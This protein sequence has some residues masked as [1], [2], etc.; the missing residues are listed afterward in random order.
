M[1]ATLPVGYSPSAIAYDSGKGEIFVAI[2]GSN[3]VSVIS[4]SSNT[5]VANV[6]VGSL[7]HGVAYDSSKGE[8]F[9]ANTNDG[10]VSV[11]SDVSGTSVSSSPTVPE[12]SNQAL[13]LVVLAMVAVTF[14]KVALALEKST[15][16]T[17]DSKKT[18]E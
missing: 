14:C 18:T 15:R 4:D 17:S 3:S 12:F 5:V 9:V 10:T 2:A 13:I 8:I 11:I 7:P 16:T 1:V 6:T